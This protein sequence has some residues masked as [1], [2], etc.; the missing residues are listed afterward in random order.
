MNVTSGAFLF[1][2]SRMFK[3]EGSKC[4]CTCARQP[5]KKRNRI[6]TKRNRPSDRD[7]TLARCRA[8]PP[9]GCCCGSVAAAETSLRTHFRARAQPCR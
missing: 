4:C 2:W 8:G 3:G 9:E 1:P 7:R 6:E 5:L